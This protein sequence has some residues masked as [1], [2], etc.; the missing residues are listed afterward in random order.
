MGENKSNTKPRASSGSY[1]VVGT[2][3][4]PWPNEEYPIGDYPD[5]ESAMEA[6]QKERQDMTVVRIYDQ[7]GTLVAYARGPG[8]DWSLTS[9]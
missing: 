1:R 9:D 2:D 5:L 7:G 6:G 8:K 4:F 3:T